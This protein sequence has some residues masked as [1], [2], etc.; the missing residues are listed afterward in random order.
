MRILFS[1]WDYHPSAAGGA[2]KQ[3]RLQAEELVRRGHVVEV[4]CPRTAGYERGYTTGGVRVHRLFRIERRPFQRVTY[5]LAMS[6]FLLRNLRRFDVVHVHLANLQADVV[7]AFCR[8][9]GRPSYVKLASGGYS[10][11][12]G[13]LRRTARLT[14]WYGLRHATRVQALSAELELE[15]GSIGVP[16]GKVVRIP[17]GMDFDGYEAAGDAVRRSR[18]AE[19]GLPVDKQIVLFI[20]R[21]SRYKGVEDLLGAWR[22]LGRDDAVLVMVGA[23]EVTDDPIGEIP[24]DGSVITRGWQTDVRPYLQAADVF[25]SPSHADG[26]SNALLEAMASGLAIVATSVGAAEEMLAGGAAGVLAPPQAPDRLA[27]AIRE[28]LD[29]P[30]RRRAVADAARTEVQRYALPR[31]VGQIE[32]AYGQ[33]AAR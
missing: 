13:R 21:F 17:N 9:L 31:I 22:R 27:D 19:L 4:M 6:W 1:T 10:G 26:M 12:I 2:E 3:A 25:V 8:L 24:A 16:S 30:A 15:L 14:R 23:T 18:R 5:L 29:D 33:I 32:D 7:V 11:E 20:G 28:L